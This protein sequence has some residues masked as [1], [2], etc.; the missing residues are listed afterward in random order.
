VGALSKAGSSCVPS[1]RW[2]NAVLRHCMSCHVPGAV[3]R[4]VVAHLPSTLS[5]HG[6]ASSSVTGPG[7]ATCGS[8]GA[9]S[10]YDRVHVVMFVDLHTCCSS[11][12]TD[13]HSLF[14]FDPLFAQL[15]WLAQ[16]W[17]S[18]SCAE[19]LA[20]AS[21]VPSCHAYFFGRSRCASS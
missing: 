13:V 6:T 12:S 1:K 15:C 16:C 10:R 14:P 3:L 20:Q 9:G 4:V 8:L 11:P 19:C 7:T 18:Q 21:F 2:I 5:S 17:S